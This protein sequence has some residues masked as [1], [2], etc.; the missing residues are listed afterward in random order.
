M[1]KKDLQVDPLKLSS[2]QV[3][4]DYYKE[5]NKSLKA[6]ERTYRNNLQTFNEDGYSRVLTA[7]EILNLSPEQREYMLS[8]DR[9]AEF[10]PEQQQIIEDVLRELRADPEG[11]KEGY[12]KD[13][14]EK[15]RRL[16]DTKEAYDKIAQ[17]PLLAEDYITVFKNNL[18]DARARAYIDYIKENMF[19]QLDNAFTPSVAPN[20][21]NTTVQQRVRDLIFK[22]RGIPYEFLTEYADKNPERAAVIKDILDLAKYWEDTLTVVKSMTNVKD[23]QVAILRTIKQFLE[24]SDDV[25]TLVQNLE[26]FIDADITNESGKYTQQRVNDVLDAVQG[27]NH[28][29][30]SN[31]VK[32]REDKRQERLAEEKANKDKSEHGENFDWDGFTKGDVIYNTSNGNEFVVEGFARDVEGNN[33]MVAVNP[34]DHTIVYFNSKFDKDIISKT[35]PEKPTTPPESSAK[36]TIELSDK[37]VVLEADET[38]PD[39]V[40]IDNEGQA[41]V[42]ETPES[43]ATETP[44]GPTYED[45]T[46]AVEEAPT[47]QAVMQGN[48]LTQYDFY[49]L[50]DFQTQEEFK[51]SQPSGIQYFQWLKDNGIKLQEIVDNEVGKIFLKYP[52]TP[53]RILKIKPTAE[54]DQLG[55]HNV[56]VVEATPEIEALH[57]ST[58]GNYI[59]AQG[60][61]WLPI[62]TLG[63]SGKAQQRSYNFFTKKANVNSQ[64]YFSSNP[65]EQYY[66][67]QDSYTNIADITSGFITRRLLGDDEVKVRTLGELLNDPMRNPNG[68]TLK[69]LKWYLQKGKKGVKIGLTESDTF[70]PPRDTAGNNGR[71]FIALQAANGNYIPLAV[72]ATVYNELKVGSQLRDLIEN[73]LDNIYN[74]DY[75]TRVLAIK[76]LVRLLNLTDNDNILIGRED[77]STVTIKQGG[78]AVKTFNPK[79]CR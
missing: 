9:R 58:R 8:E 13:S 30:D 67:E 20:E 66:V 18:V 25:N 48:R 34:K 64:N 51:P 26:A 38:T 35:K 3:Q 69:N 45:M 78:V 33:M 19:A 74:E 76:E 44:L 15:Q 7:D 16:R 11:M 50:R 12:I 23:E 2:L 65:T 62:G 6:R 52:N 17:N 43:H 4:I 77:N 36:E 71:V 1:L 56:L 63:Y 54:H 68:L 32:S 21:L 72:R 10:S 46:E 37:P 41:K 42:V 24:K 29:R 47:S 49:R 79:A 39:E 70:F 57:D 61:N 31:K 53:V 40:V 27:M 28:L 59:H 5:Q 75:A 73:H 55:N 60:K 22:G 14:A